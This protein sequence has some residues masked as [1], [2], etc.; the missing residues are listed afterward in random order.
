MKAW[1][2]LRALAVL[3]A[4]FAAGHSIFHGLTSRLKPRPTKNLPTHDLAATTPRIVLTAGIA[5]F[6][7]A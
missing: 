4:I 3:L 5:E 7:A 1:I 2:W 6:K